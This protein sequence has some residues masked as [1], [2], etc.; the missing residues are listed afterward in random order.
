MAI[1]LLMFSTP[2]LAV[3]LA[4]LR[5]HTLAILTFILMNLAILG[6]RPK[7]TALTCFLFVL[8][9][10]AFYVPLAC[11]GGVFLLSFLDEAAPAREWRK[12]SWL[13]GFGCIAGLLANPYFPG[14]IA[15]AAIHARIP[16]LM[17]GELRGASFGEELVPVRSDAHFQ[18]FHG[19][20]LVIFLAL[21][22]LG[23]DIARRDKDS[24]ALRVRL[25]YLLGVSGFFLAVSFQIIR[26]GEYLIPA[27]GLILVLLLERWKEYWKAATGLACVLALAQF[28]FLSRV[29]HDRA[30]HSVS[31][32]VQETFKAIA[33]I[34]AE[35]RGAKV[36]NCEWDRTP[37]LLYARPDLRFIDI[38]D[39]SLLY[40]AKPGAY[41]ARE[42]L[43][44]GTSA[45]AYGLIRNAFKADYVLCG[46]PGISAQ[47]R[48]DPG[49]EQIYPS[50]QNPGQ[51]TIV[52]S[53]FRLL[54]DPVPAYVRSLAISEPSAVEEAKLSTLQP[55]SAS[56]ARKEIDLDKSSYLNLA[57]LLPG[58]HKGSEAP[59]L[60]CAFIS[61]SNPEVERLAGANFLGVGGG[62]GLKVWLN[63]VPLFTTRAGFPS[64][65]L[66]QVLL[67][68]SVPLRKTDKI[69][70]LACSNAASPFWGVAISLW[71]H[72][73]IKATCSRKGAALAPPS[74]DLSAWPYQGLQELTCLGPVAAPAPARDI[75]NKPTSVSSQA[76]K[77]KAP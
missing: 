22:F 7:L 75:T 36:F 26:A 45:D 16:E 30:L 46:D 33:A 73:E 60:Q 61:P 14:N 18:I 47:L 9:Y 64:A 63:G 27:C 48:S 31:D 21:F 52:L 62:Q 28:V 32:R 39:P 65:H 54:P 59:P 17:Q 51:P 44:S 35:P 50:I 74:V 69:D 11:M 67:P 53:L 71:S 5:P 68:L 37:Y 25:L 6:R 23:L 40:F 57:A 24:K 70:V 58:K 72:A 49:F 55:P 77:P 29:L 1:S 42:E 34:P 15:L 4:L 41:R 10:H 13:G 43:R 20:M 38:L 12:L 66:I 76:K 8:S 3:R 56:E 19:P 2:F